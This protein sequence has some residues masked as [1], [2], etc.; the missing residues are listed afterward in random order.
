MRITVDVE[1]QAPDM[2]RASDVQQ[3]LECLHPNVDT[4][5]VTDKAALASRI[6]D[7]ISKEK[8]EQISAELLDRFRFAPVVEDAVEV[9]CSAALFNTQRVEKGDPIYPFISVITCLPDSSKEKVKTEI[10]KRAMLFLST[11]RRLDCSRL[12]ILPYAETIA[13]MT[14]ANLLNVRSVVIAIAQ[15]IRGDITRTAG[16]TCLGKLVEM[17]FDTL[18]QCDSST[19]ELIRSTVANAQQDDTFLYDVEYIME[20]FGWSQNKPMLSVYR[21][22]THHHHAILSLAYCGGVGSREAVVTS[23]VDGTIGTWDRNG[24]LTEN[25]ILSRHYAASLDL[26]NRG[27]T[28]IVGMVGRN[29]NTPPA[30]VL[31]A[32][33]GTARESHWEEHG[34]VEPKNARFITCVRSVRSAAALRYG[35]GVSTASSHPLIIY[36]NTQLVQEYHNHSDILTA[37]HIPSDRDT[38]VITGSRDRS[39]M[40]YDLRKRQPVSNLTHHYSSV[41]AIGTC[42][43]YLFTGGIDKRIVVEDMRMLG[44]P[45]ARDMDSAVLSLSVSTA[46][47]C[48]VST[49]TGI[50]TIS[51][52]GQAPTSSRAEC[53]PAAPRY[54]AIWWNCTGNVLY[55]GGENMSLDIFT[56]PFGDGDFFETA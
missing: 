45:V 50:Y 33:E 19:L 24:T 26:A 10:A 39:I 14:K 5:Y 8:Y 13:A 31:Y 11:P 29:S 4:R 6:A 23:S 1:L 41:S 25:I 21:S 51:S 46:S 20:S 36:D 18:R 54:N 38:T 43:D 55:A 2:G 35:V 44:H 32:E 12:P 47:Q 48:A 17:S 49:L 7:A 34:A 52:D 3:A 30:V 37:M 22:C 53:G 15:M 40:I 28:M 56:K 9:L 27:H 42:G 16:M